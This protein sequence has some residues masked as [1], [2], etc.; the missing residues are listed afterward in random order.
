MELLIVLLVT[1]IL[2]SMMMPA[3][4]KVRENVHRV[5]C[6]SN[7][8]QIGIAISMYADDHKDRLPA[9]SKLTNIH[10]VWEPQELM[11][12]FHHGAWDGLGLLYQNEYCPTP[13]CFYCPSH[14]GE[15]PFQRYSMQWE[16]PDG[17]STI[18]TNFH[19]AG[20]RDWITGRIR[21]YANLD[22]MVLATD[23]LRTASDFN[24]RVG[25][26]TLRG[27]GAVRWRDDGFSI[28][29]LLPDGQTGSADPEKY[30]SIWDELEK[31]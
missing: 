9:S 6:S 30:K 26:N 16:R 12:A 18:Y 23:G 28:M 10:G 25:L 27:D 17:S 2:A 3:M 13:S 31:N 4:T 21:P 11:G 5:V 19:Y 7:L 1:S 14:R 29:V 24:H 22:R 8:R 15:H 20:H